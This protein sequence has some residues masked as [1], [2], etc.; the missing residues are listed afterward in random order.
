MVFMRRQFRV[1][2]VVEKTFGFWWTGRKNFGFQGVMRRNSGFQGVMRKKIGFRSA[3]RKKS[4]F[5]GV[6]RKNFGFQ[7]VM[8]R[9]KLGV[10]QKNIKLCLTVLSLL[11]FSMPCT[12]VYSIGFALELLSCTSPSMEEIYAS[13]FDLFGRR[14]VFLFVLGSRYF[15][16][17]EG[18][19]NAFRFWEYEDEKKN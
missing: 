8:E 12:L 18:N 11:L 6:M 19:C 4:G 5:Q 3:T 13:K 14:Q 10:T 9:S 1:W 16:N 15:F 2:S 7:C 17:L